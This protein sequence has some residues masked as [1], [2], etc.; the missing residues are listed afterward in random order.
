MYVCVCAH[1]QAYLC[2][3]ICTYIYI[4][5]YMHMYI[6]YVDNLINPTVKFRFTFLDF[7]VS[8]LGD[9]RELEF[10]VTTVDG[11]NPA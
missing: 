11:Q 4:D 8:G 5:M 3:Y 6:Y 7:E 9:D 10:S 2:T 1:V